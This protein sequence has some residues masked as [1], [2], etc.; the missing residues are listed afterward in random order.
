MVADVRLDP[1]EPELFGALH[2]LATYW[3][4]DLYVHCRGAYIMR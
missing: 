1:D 4:G 2:R 3:Q